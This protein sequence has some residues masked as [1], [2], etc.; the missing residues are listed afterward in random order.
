MGSA[1]TVDAAA[2]KVATAGGACAG[3]VEAVAVGDATLPSPP[4]SSQRTMAAAATD[5]AGSGGIRAGR[6]LL[7]SSVA[8]GTPLL[9]CSS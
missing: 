1:G 7:L 8:T 3:R 4:L 9:S 2:A 5:A 6:V